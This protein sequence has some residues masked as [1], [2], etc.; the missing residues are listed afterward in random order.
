MTFIFYILGVW[1]LTHILVASKILEG[2]R[3]WLLINSPFFGDM[4]NCYQCTSFWASMILYFFF[5]NLRLET[6]DF[7][8]KGYRISPD[9]LLYSFIGSGIVSFI[10]VILSLLIKR[11]K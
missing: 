6:I 2:F 10:A 7:I 3:N 8:I 5:D 4:L 1:G 9:F 11:S